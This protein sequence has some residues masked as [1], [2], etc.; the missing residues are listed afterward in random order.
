MTDWRVVQESDGDLTLRDR[1]N[2]AIK[3]GHVGADGTLFPYP[4]DVALADQLHTPSSL[5][6]QAVINTGLRSPALQQFWSKLATIDTD[7]VDIVTIGD[8]NTEGGTATNRQKSWTN[9]MRDELR[10]RFQPAGVAGGEGYLPSWIVRGGPADPF[11]WSGGSTGASTEGLGRRNINVASGQTLTTTFTGTRFKLLYTRHSA[12]GD[13]TVTI[14]GG[15]PAT[16]NGNNATTLNSQV[17]DSGALSAASHTVSIAH[18]SGST[19]HIE[20]AIAYNGDESAGIRT[21]QGGHSGYTVQDFL[22]STAWT[23][24]L[25]VIQPDLVCMM[26]ATNDFSTLVPVATFKTRLASLIALIRASCASKPSIVL[27]AAPERYDTGYTPLA[28]YGD[29]VTAMAQVASEDGKVAFL[30]LRNVIAV[31]GDADGTGSTDADKVHF[32]TVG[33]GMIARAIAGFVSP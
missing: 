12:G 9:V 15:A 26:W 31:G 18:V 23:A 8:S 24:S 4:S 11:T 22:A 21:H 2:L 16:V 20:G 32:T 33:Q 17:W 14:D 10:R 3:L 28:P 1:S 7:G 27:A 29:Y 19:A 5:F 30:D 25:G 13:F 6:A